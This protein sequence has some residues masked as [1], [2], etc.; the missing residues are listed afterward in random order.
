MGKWSEGL[1]GFRSSSG[2]L[3]TFLMLD[4]VYI[5]LYIYI[6]TYIYIHIYILAHIHAIA[7]F[8]QHFGVRSTTENSPV[9]SHPISVCLLA[10]IVGMKMYV[11]WLAISPRW[12]GNKLHSSGSIG[13][14]P[15]WDTTITITITIITTTPVL[16]VRRGSRA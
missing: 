14:P 6:H 2:G 12:E 4:A 1:A 15:A 3:V 11:H 5:Y 10:P 8:P 13:L 9:E 7:T 16:Y